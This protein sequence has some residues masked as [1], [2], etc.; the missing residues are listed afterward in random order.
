MSV[1]FR[2]SLFWDCNLSTLDV[3]KHKRQIIVRVL[4]R[5]TMEDWETIKNLYGKATILE[6]AQQARS[7]TKYAL[8]FCSV[9]FGVPK[10]EFR[11]YTQIAYLQQH[12]TY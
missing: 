12:W 4:E 9:Y 11:C 1:L 7:L 3:E 2:Q 10:E 8:S 6:E 5:G